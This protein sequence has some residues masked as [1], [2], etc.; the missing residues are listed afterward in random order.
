MQATVEYT[1]EL[2]AGY[3]VDEMPDPV[4]LDLGF[5]AYQSGLEVK[6]NTLHYTRTFTVRQVTLPAERYAD[7][8]KMASVIAA[9]E[10][11]RA[12]LKKQ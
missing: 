11:N 12:V 5:A 3:V 2:P 1:I 8:Q 9:D 6:G 4:K 10:E 7:V